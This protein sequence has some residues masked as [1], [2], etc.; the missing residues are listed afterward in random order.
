MSKS[1]FH[2]E[3]HQALR[4]S[5]ALGA[6]MDEYER[7]ATE[8]KERIALLPLSSYTELLA[9]G[10]Q[11]RGLGSIRIAVLQVIDRGFQIANLIR[12]RFGMQEFT[13]GMR[14]ETP[15]LA[16]MSLNAMLACTEGAL[17]EHW[18]LD[19]A[20]LG[21][22]Q[23]SAPWGTDYSLEQLLEHAIVL[24]LRQCRIVDHYLEQMQDRRGR[25]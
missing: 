22:I 7:S 3:P 8:L 17:A 14:A 15:E 2:M 20:E 24:I 6:L 12:R 10:V 9:E 18:D 23:I 1:P 5:G 25:E 4:R 16:A 19:E 13:H 21:T 11:L